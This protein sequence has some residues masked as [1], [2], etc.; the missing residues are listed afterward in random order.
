MG[1]NPGSN[2]TETSGYGWRIRNGRRDNHTGID[3][4][5]ERGADIPAAAEG[6]VWY[7][8]N[9]DIGD[10]PGGFGHTV[11]LKHTGADGRV[12][13]TLY[14]HMD[15]VPDHLRLG[16]Q[17]SAGD[18][19]GQV[20]DSGADEGKY[21]LH[22][23]V[24]TPPEG[25]EPA[26]TDKGGAILIEPDKHRSDPNSFG[27]WPESGVYDG[28]QSTTDPEDGEGMELLDR[29]LDGYPKETKD[30]AKKEYLLDMERKR[31][32]RSRSS[33]P[34]HETLVRHGKRVER[35]EPDYRRR[36]SFYSP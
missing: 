34:C 22:F 35:I 15:T 23:E 21:H 25:K 11:I 29:I 31:R 27:N 3:Y 33:F 17:V 8:G 24:L 18:I 5:A 20:G 30:Q 32:E 7:Y 26:N 6:E 19:I 12:F 10:R 1:Y 13:Y 14:A 4:A 2:F 9:N 28:S 36:G 16:Q